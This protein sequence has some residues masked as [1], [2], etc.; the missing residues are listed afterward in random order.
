M[1]FGVNAK[2]LQVVTSTIT[3]VGTTLP[4]GATQMA[5]LMGV[6]ENCM[7]I[8]YAAS[9]VLPGL[10]EF[11]YLSVCT[12][13]G[14]YLILFLRWFLGVGELSQALGCSLDATLAVWTAYALFTHR[15]LNKNAHDQ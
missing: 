15:Y 1:F 11:V 7:T 9:G 14:A 5:R 4:Y 6:F 8:F 2:I 12:R 13:W 3:P 10:M